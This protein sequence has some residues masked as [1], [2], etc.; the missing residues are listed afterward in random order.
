MGLSVVVAILGILLARYLYSRNLQ[1]AESISRASGPLYGVLSN[2]WYV[3]EIYDF[4]FVNGLSKGGGRLLSRFDSRIVDGGVNG[5]GWLTRLTSTVSGLWDTWV[6]DGAVR[7]I[8]FLV[9]ISSYPM[10]IAQS[11][12]VQSYAFV[13]VIGVALAL[14]Y[15][16]T[17]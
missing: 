2:K 14:G 8:A 17:R 12:Y 6:V 3:D 9:K 5:A 15:F 16:L 11:G 10:R 4:L 7:L 1:A 13:I